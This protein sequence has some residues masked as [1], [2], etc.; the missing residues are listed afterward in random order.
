MS[1][2]EIVKVDH[3]SKQIV[4]KFHKPTDDFYK[5]IE[6]YGYRLTEHLYDQLQNRIHRIEVLKNPWNY[7]TEKEV[8]AL[9]GA[10]YTKEAALEK[11][12]KQYHGKQIALYSF[13]YRDYNFKLEYDEGFFRFTRIKGYNK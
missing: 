10:Y 12:A 11:A 4:V 1:E 6:N 7:V 3:M 13:P 2:A 8:N 9:V 5:C